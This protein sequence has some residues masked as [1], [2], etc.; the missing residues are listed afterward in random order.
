MKKKT[1][2]KELRL[3]R[4]ELSDLLRERVR[5]AGG[6]ENLAA[7]I[8]VSHQFLSKVINEKKPPGNKILAYLGATVMKPPET[9]I[10]T[11]EE[12]EPQD[13]EIK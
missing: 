7:K 4:K 6:L 9:Y 11:I 1:N 13:D 5:R 12:E 10:I 2:I 3:N 8:D